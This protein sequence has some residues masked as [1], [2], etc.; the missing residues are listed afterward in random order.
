M[1]QLTIEK[2]LSDTPRQR[3]TLSL[4]SRRS[5][6]LITIGGCLLFFV[7]VLLG[8]RLIGEQ[9]LSTAL[10][11][12]NLPP[13]AGHLFGTDWLGRDMLT[14]TVHGL[15][16]SLWVGLLAAG[17]SALIGAVL[18][19]LSATLGG[20]VDTLVTW[21]IDLFFSLPHLVV[22]IMI[23]FVIGGGT[24]GVIIAVTLTHWPSLARIIR[25]EVLQ[26]KSSDYVQL[27]YR[28]GR[29]PLW[30]ARYHMLPHLIPQFMVGLILL[31]PHA[32]LHEASLTFIGIGLSPHTSA[33]GVI[34][35][36]SMRYL[37]TGQWWL[38]VLP[39]ITLLC[40]V[41]MF[42]VLGSNLRAL[43]DPRTSQE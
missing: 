41:L 27:S 22:L 13:G 40:V 31:F 24:T 5:R 17:A 6:T 18:G 20:V 14:R 21:L 28:F 37:S 38:A 25:A 26:I 9:G 1:S 23:A 8:S 12:R 16:L 4:H 42:D 19:T 39:G 2:T 30:V 29:S 43:L 34:L 35:S 33:I 3:G 32:I 10:T 36:E 11:M 15:S 7:L